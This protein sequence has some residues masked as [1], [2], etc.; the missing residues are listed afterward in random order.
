MTAFQIVTIIFA[1][2]GLLGA[3]VGVYF[4]TQIDITRVQTIITFLQKDL[5]NKEVSLLK[6]ERDNKDDH[7]KILL[8]LDN[9]KEGK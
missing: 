4:K 2:L 6:L 9:L 3:I 7:E 1:G 8:K 5:D